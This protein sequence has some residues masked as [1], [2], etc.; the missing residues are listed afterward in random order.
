MGTTP[1]KVLRLIDALQKIDTRA[2]RATAG[3]R[4]VVPLPPLSEI[5]ALPRAAYFGD[6]EKI[7]LST[8][9]HG[10]NP[11]IV[12]AISADQVVPYPPGIPVLVPGQRVTEEIAGFLLDL[13]HA[14]NGIEIHGLMDTGGSPS[15]RVVAG[16]ANASIAALA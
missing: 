8:E 5:C 11:V 6:G 13:H 9:Q 4:K 12:G 16:S 10:L 3:Q 2:S 14:N 7:P 1:A 15:L